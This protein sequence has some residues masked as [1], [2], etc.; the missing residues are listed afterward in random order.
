MLVGEAEQALV[1]EGL[2]QGH[3][4]FSDDNVDTAIVGIGRKDEPE[5]GEREGGGEDGRDEEFPRAYSVEREQMGD[6]E[7]DRHLDGECRRESEE[8]LVLV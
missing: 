7:N 5:V 3:E 8:E 2:Y 4:E 1:D 6:E